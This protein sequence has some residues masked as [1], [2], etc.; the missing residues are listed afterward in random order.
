MMMVTLDDTAV[1]ISLGGLTATAALVGS[2]VLCLAAAHALPLSLSNARP[3]HLRQTW[4]LFAIV[5]F[6]LGMTQLLHLESSLTDWLRNTAKHEGLYGFRRGAQAIAIAGLLIAAYTI[7]RR[8]RQMTGDHAEHGIKW[9]WRGI[10]T[11]TVVLAVDLV[12]WHYADWL[13]GLMVAGLRL[14]NWLKIFGLGMVAW[15]CLRSIFQP[16]SVASP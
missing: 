12:S 11:V 3:S 9:A 10:V 14:G 13:F 4:R 6:I 1:A 16:P 5:L 2:G 7:Y 15:G 8:V